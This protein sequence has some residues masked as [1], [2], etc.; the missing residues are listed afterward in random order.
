MASL[1]EKL[2]RRDVRIA[3]K[4]LLEKL[5]DTYNE[6]MQGVRSR[7]GEV[8]KIARS[9]NHAR[10]DLEQEIKE[11]ALKFLEHNSKLMCSYQVTHL[12]E[13]QYPGYS[14]RLT[15]DTTG[16]EI[17]ASFGLA[18]MAR[19]LLEKGADANAKDGG[20]G[21]ALHWAAQAWHEVVVQLL[22][23]K[24]ADVNMKGGDGETALHLAAQVGHEA[25][26]WP[27]TPL[28]PDVQ[29][30]LIQSLNHFK[31]FF[32]WASSGQSHQPPP[33]PSL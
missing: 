33:L 25:V 14:Q 9:G 19:L 4:Y 2:N 20:G 18:E 13:Y 1:A 31:T 6:A 10:R 21:T 29:N 7:G 26:M 27:I 17:A 3:L 23:K 16:L 5:N 8:I 32:P 24:R 22:L 28:T 30:M 11:L 15:K 12:P